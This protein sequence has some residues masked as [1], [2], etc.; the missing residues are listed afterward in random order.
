MS[1][2]QFKAFLSYSHAADGN[3]AP[4]IQAALHRFGR[5]WYRIRTMWI[6]R[7]KTG[8]SATPSLWGSIEAALAD[9]E[10][11]LL[12]ASPEAATSKWVQQEVD[13]WLKKRS[14]KTILVI[15]TD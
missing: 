12:M 10:Y 15:L 7:D 2:P 8:L 14:T 9:S 4:A 3:L 1:R 13:W 11:F 6:F 5:P